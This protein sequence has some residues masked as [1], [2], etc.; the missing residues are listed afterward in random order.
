MLS[1]GEIALVNGYNPYGEPN[2]DIYVHTLVATSNLPRNNNQTTN[3]QGNINQVNNEIS[4]NVN[5]TN[6]ETQSNRNEISI[7][8][9]SLRTSE[10][11]RAIL[12]GN[13]NI[14]YSNQERNNNQSIFNQNNVQQQPTN[15]NFNNLENI[16][17]SIQ[18]ILI[19]KI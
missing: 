17:S 5:P 3:I 12:N 1:P 13:Q 14:N 18:S 15:Q 19:D 6:T 11:T 2:I 8:T 10:L 4:L 9:E 16:I 7:Q